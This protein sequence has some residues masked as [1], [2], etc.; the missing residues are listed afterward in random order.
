[1]AITKAILPDQPSQRRLKRLQDDFMALTKARLSMLTVVTTIFGYLLSAHA[2]DNFSWRIVIHLVIGTCLAAFGAAVFNQLMEVESDSRMSRTANRPLPANRLPKPA[3]FILGW[4]FCAFGLIHLGMTV[5]VGASMCAAATLIT[6]LFFYTPLKRRSSINTIV[7]AVSGA[8]PPLIGWA[9]A[10]GELLSLGAGYV[11]GL[12]FFWQL[13]HFAAINWIYR[14][15]YLAGG[16]KMWSNDDSSGRL[17]ARLAVLFSCCVVAIGGIYPLVFGLMTPLGGA[18]GILLG[19][20]MVVL[21]VKFLK[22]PTRDDARILFFFT[23]I[24]L[25]CIMTAAYLTWL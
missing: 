25:P 2:L 1:M 20:V 23:L 5:N 13:P 10:G 4:L 7:G 3:A 14:E 18:I 12:L 15:E 16:F 24:F 21:S 19:S 6:Y 8:L 11:A 22:K 17:T 9:A